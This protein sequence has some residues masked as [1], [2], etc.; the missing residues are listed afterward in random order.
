[1][2]LIN[3]FKRIPAIS[4]KL[5]TKLALKTSHMIIKILE[6]LRIAGVIAGYIIAYIA[7]DTPEETLHTLT[8]WIIVSIAGLSGI[9]GLFF[10]KKAA[11]EKGFETGSNYQ[12]Q[13]AFAFLSMAAI[14]ILVYIM[15][16]GVHADLTISFVFLLFLFLSSINH[17]WQAIEHKNYK[18]NNLIRPFQTILLIAIYIYPIIK[19][20]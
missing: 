4:C 1:M 15:N 18:W 20:L 6:F 14:A 3:E 11:A 10:S 7:I 8:L 19:V 5:N 9:E 2:C 13:S 17:A 16:W 12:I